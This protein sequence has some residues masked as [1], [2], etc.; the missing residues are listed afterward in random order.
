MALH[1]NHEGSLLCATSVFSV[2]LWLMNPSK[3]HYKDAENT[4]T[5]QRNQYVGT[6][7]TKPSLIVE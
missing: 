7:C 3:T 2:S 1:K 6:F 4:E 5:A